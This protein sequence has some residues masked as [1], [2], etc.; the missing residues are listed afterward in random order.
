M[1]N[2]GVNEM[3]K[4]ERLNIRID[5]KA[6]DQLKEL[7]KAENRTISNYIITLIQKEYEKIKGR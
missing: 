7:A 4:E 6:K 3:N 1:R 5:S 2:K